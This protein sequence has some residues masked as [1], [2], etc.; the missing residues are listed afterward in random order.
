[1]MKFY[2][3]RKISKYTMSILTMSAMSYT[4][5]TMYTL[6]LIADEISTRCLS[7]SEFSRMDE[8]CFFRDGK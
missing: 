7:I 4:K 2:L 5:K 6:I 3:H 8:L 1:M